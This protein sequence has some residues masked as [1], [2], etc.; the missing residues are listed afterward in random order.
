MKY[1]AIVP[2]AAEM[3]D[4]IDD[5]YEVGAPNL[6]HPDHGPDDK[7]MIDDANTHH[8]DDFQI[9]VPS[10]LKHGNYVS[11]DEDSDDDNCDDGI[12]KISYSI[13]S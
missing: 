2:L 3:I 1:P 10:I 8:N 7:I 13:G 4:T 12:S 11:D 5:N 6:I 9:T